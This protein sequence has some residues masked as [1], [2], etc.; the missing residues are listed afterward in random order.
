M[1]NL[2]INIDRN[3]LALNEIGFNGAKEFA[4]DMKETTKVVKQRKKFVKAKRAIYKLIF[5]P[6]D[7]ICIKLMKSERFS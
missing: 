3:T 5:H 4:N 6:K 7:D 2:V 1:Q